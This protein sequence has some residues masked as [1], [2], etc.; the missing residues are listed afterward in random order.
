MNYFFAK[1]FFKKS[2]S[3]TIFD[4]TLTLAQSLKL[5]LIYNQTV[6]EGKTRV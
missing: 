4:E 6:S 1:Q 5:I 2:F 3:N